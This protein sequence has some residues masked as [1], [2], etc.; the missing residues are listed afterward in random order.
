MLRTV[1]EREGPEPREASAHRRP[2]DLVF[3]VGLV[4]VTSVLASVPAFDS[5]IVGVLFGIPFV[6]FVPGYAL[7]AALF[8]E[9]DSRSNEDEIETEVAERTSN[10]RARRI[11]GFERLVLSFGTSIAVVPLVALVLNFTP[12][13]VRPGPVLFS[14][15]GVTIVFA[16]VGT[17]RRR[18]LPLEERFFVPYRRWL[19]NARSVAFG[20][21]ARSDRI[22]TIAVAL[23]VMLTLGSVAYT[24]AV[25]RGGET[26]TE[27][28]LL[29]EDEDGD[30]VAAGYPTELTPGER[31]RLYVGIENRERRPL[32]YTVVVAL[33][34]VQPSNGSVR[35]TNERELHRFETRLTHGESW[36]RRHAVVP[37]ITG[38]RLRLTYLLYRG[39][40]P[41]D[42][43]VRNAYREVHIWIN[44]SDRR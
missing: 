10:W 21:G 2:A 29:T 39:E 14:I 38:D 34:Q 23:A 15:G 42:S 18:R 35:V 24:A 31:E 12:F 36:R 25:P 20:P 4:V 17:I 43:T 33:Q 7:V 16:V 9:T 19:K 22:A 5:A 37:Q 40:P 26:F 11:D 27:L 41:A 30:L 32:N 44:G 6:L 3:I 13:G 1:P 8:P 28:Y